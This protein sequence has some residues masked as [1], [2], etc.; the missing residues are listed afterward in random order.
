LPQEEK[1]RTRGIL[2]CSP[3]GEPMV[4]LK[5]DTPKNLSTFVRVAEALRF[6][7]KPKANSK[8]KEQN[9]KLQIKIQN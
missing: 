7:A 2:E 5:L 9:V 1:P 6:G 3:L 8:I 4:K